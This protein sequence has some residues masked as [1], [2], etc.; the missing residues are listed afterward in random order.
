MEWT[1]VLVFTEDSI[2]LLIISGSEIAVFIHLAL[3]STFSKPNP[4]V[5]VYT[6]NSLT[7]W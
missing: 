1:E 7:V 2:L 4:V 6:F 5:G 3:I